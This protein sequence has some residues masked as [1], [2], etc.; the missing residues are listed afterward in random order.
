MRAAQ[1]QSK[2][3]QLHI[4][5]FIIK[6]DKPR[7][8]TPSV[9]TQETLQ[10]TEQRLRNTKEAYRPQ[11][12]EWLDSS[13]AVHHKVS[14]VKLNRLIFQPYP[15]ELVFQ[16]FT[17]SQTYS[18]PLLLRNNDKVSQPVRLELQDSEQ[19]YVLGPE[20]GSSKVAPEMAAL[21]TVFFTPQENKDYHYRLVCVTQ[22]ERF[23]I[24]VRAVGPRA[25][26]DFQDEICLPVCPVKASTEKTQLVRNIGKSK[27]KFKL[28]TQRP[29]SVTP[30]SGTLDVGEILQVTV[31]FQPTTVGDHRQELRLHYHTGEDVY[32]SL[33]GTCKELKIQLETDFLML[34]NTYINMTDTQTVSLTNESDVP[35]RYRWAVWRSQKQEDL[36]SIRESSVLQ[37]GEEEE[38]EEEEEKGTFQCEFDPSAIHHL[39]LLS[40]SL[41]KCRSQDC[42]LALSLSCITVEPMEGEIFPNTTAQFKIVF[43]P[44]EAILYQ[45]TIYCDV[46]G[47]ESRLPLTIQGEGLGPDLQL[48]YALIDMKNVFIGD[49]DRYE[50]QLSNKGPIDSPFR[51]L[52][53]DTTFGRCFSVSPEEGVVPPRACQIVEVTFQSHILGSFIEDLLLTVTGQPRPPTLTFR[54][55]VIGPTFHFNVCELNFGDVAFGFPATVTCTL[56]N[57]SFVPL[58]FALRV[59]GDGSEFPS[60]SGAKQVSDL[61]L[62]NW[63]GH[64]AQGPPV[65]FTVS[66]AAGSVRAMSD[67]TIEVTLCSNTVR[68]YRLVLVV[69]VEDVEKE[70]YLPINARCVVPDVIVE[71][72]VLDFQRCYLNHPNEQ[73]VRLTN[74]SALPAFYG[75]LDQENEEGAP[76]VF[77]SSAPRGVLL[78]GGSEELPVFLE[79]K[80][81]GKLRCSLRIAVFGSLQPL[82]VVLSC[83]GQGPVVHVSSTQLHFGRVPVLTDTAR[84][85]QLFNQSPI[86]ALFSTRMDCKKS[87]WRVEPSEGEVQPE[88]QLELKIVVHLKDK[89]HF[90]D[91]LEVSIQDSKTHIVS[92]SATGTGTTIISDKPFGPS[93]DLGTH[94]SH[95][96]CKYSFKLTNCGQRVHR[97]FWKTD[98]LCPG[99]SFLPPISSPKQR[100]ALSRGSLLSTNREKPALSLSPSRVELFPGDSVDMVLTASSDS[101]KIIKER[102]V[103]H[104]IIGLQGCRETIMSVNVTCRFVDP[105]LSISS[106]QLNFYRKKV[107]GKILQPAYEKLVLRNV[108]SLPLS[109]ELSLPEPFFLC[110]AQLENSSTTTKVSYILSAFQ[111]WFHCFIANLRKK[112]FANLVAYF[113]HFH[114]IVLRIIIKVFF[115]FFQYLVLGDEGEVELWVCFDPTF[116]KNQVSQIVDELLKIRFLEHPHQ[117]TVELHAEVHHPNLHFSAT[118]VDFGC[119]V[120]DLKTSQEISITNVSPLHVSY[121]WDF[122]DNHK[123]IH[124]RD[125]GK[126]QMKPK[127]SDSQSEEQRSSSPVSSLPPSPGPGADEQSCTPHPAHVEE[128]FDISPMRGLLPPGEREVVT[129]SFFGHEDVSREVVAQCHVA[130]GPTYEV[131]LKGETSGISYGLES[132]HLDFGLQLFYCVGEVELTVTNTGKVGFN[133]SITHPQSEEEEEKADEGGR[134][135][136]KA[137]KDE[138]LGKKL[139]VRPGWPM[140]IPA[141]GYINAGSKRHLRVLYLPG[142]PEVF[143]KQLWLQV[144]SQPP[145]KISL[146]G[147]GVFPRI[148]LN[149]PR[150]MSEERYREA[151]QQAEAAV[152]AERRREDL[153]LQKTSGG[154]ASGKAA[155]TFEE[156][157]QMETERLLVKENA[158]VLT[159]NLLELRDSPSS[160]FQWQKLS[161]SELPEYVL[162]FGLVIPDKAVSQSVNITNNG[163]VPVSFHANCKRL[164]GTGFTAEFDH[165]KNLLCGE[166]QTFTVTFDPDEPDL[167]TGK[168]DVLLPIQVA[169][170][171]QVKVRLCAAVA[172]PTITVSTGTLQFDT[173]QCCMCQI[174]TVQLMNPGSVQCQWSMTEE[175]KPFKKIDKFL[176]LYERKKLLQEQR[177]PPTVFEMLPCSGEL[178]PGERVNVHVKFSPA[179][180]RSYSRRLEVRVAHSTQLLFITAQGQGEEP[181]LEFCPSEPELGPCL[182]FSMEAEAE[183]TVKNPGSFPI[184]FYSLEFDTEHFK[185]DEVLRLMSG[186]DENNMLLLPPRVPGEGLPPELL[187]FYK[188]CSSQLKDD[189]LN[190]EML[191]DQTKK[192]DTKKEKKKPNDDMKPADFF[193]SELSRDG[194][195]WRLGPLER[196]PVFRAIARH[197]GLDLS[198]EGPV[199]Q[200]HRGISLIVYGAPQTDKSSAAAALAAHY[201]AACLNVDAVVSNVIQ[202][203]TSPVSLSA[204]Q[205]YDAAAEEYA[206]NKAAQADAAQAEPAEPA[207][208]A[209]PPLGS[210][211]A[212]LHPAESPA[213]KSESKCSKNISITHQETGDKDTSFCELQGVDVATLSSLLPEQLLVDILVERFQLIDCHRGVVIDGLTS[214]YTHSLSSTLQIILKALNNRKHIYVVNLSDTY[215]ALKARERQQ[216]EAEEALQKERAIREEKWLWELDQETF[217]ALSEEEK[218]RITHKHLVLLRQQRL[219]ELEQMAKEEEMRKQEE[220]KRLKEEE[221][222]KKSTKGGK[223]DTKDVPKKKNLMNGKQST[224]TVNV[225]RRSSSSNSK[226]SLMDT[227]EQ[228]NLN[229]AAGKLQQSKEAE[230]PLKEAEETKPVHAVSPQPADKTKK[231]KCV[232]DE[233]QRQFTE[234]EQ[235]QVAVEHI[236]RHWDRAQGLLLVPVP[237]EELHPGPDDAVTE[238]QAPAPKKSKK[239]NNKNVSP[240]LSQPAAEANNK[241]GDSESSPQIIRHIVLNVPSCSTELLS[242]GSLPPLE[243]VL[244]LGPSSPPILPPTIFSVVPF[245][246]LRDQTKVEQNCF[247]FLVVSSLDEEE[248]KKDVEEETHAKEKVSYRSHKRSLRKTSVVKEKE[249]RGKESERSKFDG[250]HSLSQTSSTSDLTDHD[251]HQRQLEMK[252][253]QSLSSF[254]WVV[255]AGGEVILKI[256]FYSE[257]PGVF[258]QTFSFELAGSRK[259]YQLPCR[260]LCTYPSICKEYKTLF[261]H[262]KKVP[263]V[264]EELQKS[265]IIKAEYFEF[266]PLLCSKTRDRFKKNKYPENSERLVIHNN[267]SL[268]AEV[269]F[270]FLQDTQA[271]TYLLDPPTMTLAPG[272]KQELTVWAYPTKQGQIKDSVVCNIKDN[273]E[274]VIINVS[275]WG[276][277]PELELES[278]HLHFGRI[279]LHRRDSRSVMMYNTTAL[280]VSWRLQGVEDL[281]DEFVV[282]QDQGVISAN[283]SFLFTVHF[284]AKRPVLIKKILRLEVSDV[285]NILGIVH[286]ENIHVTT[287]SYDVDLEITP[288]AALDFGTIRVFEET[289]QSL[290]LINKGKYELFFKFTTEQTDPP[291][292]N[293]ES[294]FT[295]SPPSGSIMPNK[296]SVTLQFTC[297]PDKELLIKEQPVLSCQVIEPSIGKEE[298]SL[299]HISIKTSVQAVFSRYKITP[300]CD[301]DFGPLVYGTKKTQTITIENNGLF[302]MVF[303]INRVISDPALQTSVPGKMIPGESFSA[304]STGTSIK[305]RQESV[306]RESSIQQNR[307]TMGVFSVSPCSG[308]VQ[309]KSQQQVTVECVAE[310]PGSWNQC[311]LI[312]VSGRDPSGQPDG[313]QYRLLAEVFKPGI[314]LNTASIFEEHFLCRSSSQLSSEPFCDA[315]G[316]YVLKENRFTFNEVL[317][318]RTAQARFRLTNNSKISCMLSLTIKYARTKVPRQMEVFGLPATTLNIPAQSHAFAVV[319][320]TP[321][322]VQHYSATFEATVEGLLRMTPTFKNKLLEFELTGEGTLPSVCVVRPALRNG[323]GSPVMQFGRVLVGRRKTLPLVLLNDGNV[324]AQVLIEMPDKDGMFTLQ[325]A[326][327]N[328]SNHSTQLQDTTDS[329]SQLMHGARLKLKSN[330]Q[331]SFEL[332]FCSDKPAG[333]EAKLTVKVED[334]QY[335]TVI[336]VTGE[337][338]RDILSLDN[339]SRCLLGGRQEDEGDYEVLHFG[340]CHV[341]CSYRRSFTM[342]NHSSSQVL[343]FQWLLPGP[344]IIFSPQVGH[345]HASSSKEVTVSFRSS[346]PVTLSNKPVGCK[347]CQVAF[348]EPV[349]QVVDWDDRQRTTMRRQ[350]TSTSSASEA[351][352]QPKIKKTDP[353]PVCSVIEGSH[354]ELN[355]H[356]SAVCDY[357]K[358]SCRTDNI[359][360]KDTIIFQTRI[361]QLQIV[362]VGRVKVEFTWQVLMDS[363]SHDQEATGETS[364]SP[365]GSGSSGP[366][367]V[368]RPSSALSSVMSILNRNPKLPPFSVEPS[369]GTIHPGSTQNF[370]VCFS[371]VEVALVQGRLI[372]SIP[373]MQ[374]GDQAPCVQVS[375][376]S[377]LPRCHF[378]LQ[379]S[380]DIRT[381][382]RRPLDPNARVLEFK[383]VGFFTPTSRCFN[384]LNPTSEAFS[385]KWTC[386]DTAGSPFHCLTSSGTVLPGKTE[387]MRFEFVAEHRDT[388]ESLWSFV[389]ETLSLSVPFLCVG[390]AREPVVYLNR[391]HLDFGELV[392]GQR[393]E[394]TVDL[395]NAEEK[396]VHVSVLQSSL[397]SEDQQSSLVVQPMNGTVAPKNRLPLS[398]RFTPCLEGHVDF[399]LHL[400]VKGKPE[401]LTLTVKAQSSVLSMSLQ[402]KKPDGDLRAVVPNLQDTLDFGEVGISEQPSFTFLVPNPVKL[403]LE[404]NFELS[405]PKE[406]LQH[407]QAK[408]QTA[409]IKVGKSLQASLVFCPRSVCNLQDVSLNLKV[410]LGPTFTFAVKGRAEAPNLEFSFTKFNFGKCFL[411]RPGMEPPSQTLMISN[412][413][414]KDVSAECQFRNAAF[415]SV[416]FQPNILR[417]GAAMEVPV[418]FHPQ[419]ARRY[420]KNITFVFNSCVT[421]HVDIQGQGIQ[422]KLDV[423]NPQQ[424]QLKLG[425]LTLGQKVKKQAVLVNQSSS[426]LSFTLT[427]ST[428][429][430]L[431]P[432]VLSVS[433]AGELKLKS[434]GGS[435]KV[436]IQFSPRRCVPPFTAELQAEFP[437]FLH[438][439]LTVDGCCQDVEVELDQNYLSFGAVVQHCR[440]RKR[441][442]MKNTGGVNAKFQWRTEQFPAELSVAPVKGSISPGMQVPLEVTFAPVELSTDTRYENLSCSFEGSSSSVT[443]TVTGSCVAALTSKE[444]VNFVCPVRSSHTQTLSILN[445]T[446]LPVNITPVL[447]G[448]QWSAVLHVTFEPY[449]NKSFDIT[450]QPLTMTADGKK[451]VGSI[452]FSFPDGRGTLYSLQGTAD[453]PKAEGVIALELPA[454]SNHC[455]ELAVSNWLSKQQRFSVLLEIIK[456]DK[457][458]A[459]VSLKGQKY[460]EVLALAKKDYT[461]SFFAYKEGNYNTKV[462]F[463]NE[464]T[465]EYL[466]YLINFKVK[467]PGVLSTISLESTV[468]QVTS[469]TVHME[470]PL[471][472]AACF[473]SEC[474]CGDISAPPQ[475]TVPGQSE[476]SLSFEY[477]PLQ[478]GEFSTQLTLFSNDLGYFHYNLLLK[479]LPP[480]PEKTVHFETS[481][482]SSHSV[483]VKFIN[484]SRFKTEYSCK[485]DCPDFIVDKSTAASPGFQSGSEVSVEVCFEPHQQGAMKSYLTV[486]SEL[487]GEYVFPLHGVCL[488]PKPQGPFSIKSGRGVTIPFKNVFLQTTAFLF[489][490]DNSCFTVK[491]ESRIPSKKT[492]NILV[493]FDAP[494]AAF[495]GPWFGKLTISGQNYSWV[496]YLK[497]HRPSSS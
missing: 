189:E 282:P 329:G 37:Q 200:S 330:E 5:Q 417:P 353:E 201:G 152:D 493:S 64:A 429:T 91:K 359:H 238:K 134:P 475:L 313:L 234:Y 451:H 342:T 472:A 326:P 363:S 190:A 84:N 267:S 291:L 447:K 354:S 265:Y 388:V 14:S 24:P 468:R 414:R 199:A 497:G 101:P 164:A 148:T 336:R 366:P 69:D 27:A 259:L 275:C 431:D 207:E 42:L 317:V 54:G 300:A 150:N 382:R 205:L 174:Q 489:Q 206:Q 478:P 420:H 244:E 171:P 453:P 215:A 63:R 231:K 384:V 324:P 89:L 459:T 82:E 270:S 467:P 216:R 285:E 368:G 432:K 395:V 389:I 287:E 247:T 167:K 153:K 491:G 306:Q 183:V 156:L 114:N 92:V 337:A 2:T 289:K 430:P 109:I 65:E 352:P 399:R 286:T 305:T 349:E 142:V 30:S 391:P 308:A 357:V 276:V 421:Q 19:F 254:R 249:K 132:T 495:P 279:L 335:N 406:Q 461:V 60:V 80:A 123:Q 283:S 116:Y 213:E 358:F 494:P 303:T 41:Q 36:A 51:F 340:D 34:K 466:F 197:M 139:E 496:F 490:V 192:D 87:F 127:H 484:Y 261:A 121:R 194:N 145:E 105:W 462:T 473:T 309:P 50:V 448:K 410:T 299:A 250:S 159:D 62:K 210:V 33:C 237:G 209:A 40:G 122:L 333:V 113:V 38:D 470:N 29:F 411:Y 449:Q 331:M 258:E 100:D 454:K 402:V 26:L 440:N 483:L 86:P 85:L 223:K 339:T 396:E 444:V 221:S 400:K 272:Q 74:S 55:C 344:H 219:R 392:V 245:P 112:S 58:T 256:W 458:D 273:P 7:R 255:P 138:G 232:V 120:N 370:S 136:I 15:S 269:K 310:Q 474:K 435:C 412:R 325:A 394:Q 271:T 118:I 202:N 295:V 266:G 140:V 16:N 424:K 195:S 168:R 415:L 315:E 257:S 39:P 319:T 218:E 428:N 77:G 104:A 433:P 253:S 157:L 181:N 260:G 332:S 374:D 355:L 76:L 17:P 369:A 115:F 464:L 328:I 243:E 203:G 439:L 427:L 327:G 298:E 102:L 8:M 301:I 380:D 401:P 456:P 233:L 487:G 418:T 48:N 229:E 290:K 9:F 338:Y 75:L 107:K 67:E 320:F 162:D 488:P 125:T 383:A 135:Q 457:T 246:K 71:T 288:E 304:K 263:Q 225:L 44:Q 307:L 35:L 378:D 452:F 96:L 413:G 144:A 390:S 482:G 404:V 248:E 465:G 173:V 356:I 165:V 385:F 379:E 492:Q 230:D 43:Q 214:L 314:L 169:G 407:L 341:G 57:T 95:D 311:L 143:E 442:V 387:E 220:K 193:V 292:P 23:E 434:G 184:E 72:P 362:N 377:L 481:L 208:P 296:K 422:I 6:E 408:P 360:F 185:E 22:R 176:P 166:T 186:Y 480:P 381:N 108:S 97:M 236:L 68:S 66:P 25:V 312:D 172:M 419:E 227:K 425:S 361:Q 129:F 146:T 13:N 443:L 485:T 322:A 149:L 224:V 11:V 426:D 79:V 111:G 211:S 187:D 188:N 455:E 124:L 277:R 78:P 151:V 196:T 393:C 302:L 436:E 318:G 398:V 154:D 321:Q 98:G 486:S 471:T 110:D 423:K 446:G 252:R 242:H 56:F 137:L 365:P 278:K 20:N 438:P 405:G 293:L 73:T 32:I 364:T 21:F 323:E 345:L 94:F 284:R 61:S 281:G 367:P 147:A 28:H 479:A 47:R 163:S 251:Q 182:P 103:C 212:S 128:V 375:G 90:Q 445:P 371:P 343:R 294:I 373:N 191:E 441:I 81:V 297:R 175:V 126:K 130:D 10:S 316:V 222:R 179:E 460:I 93:L 239:G 119:I 372:C 106:K 228:Q 131:K 155:L 160:S 133:F 45:H 409:S 117:E 52:S 347:V 376:R 180:G 53:S 403:D 204:R 170:G 348:Q 351:S 177:P 3:P 4:N 161:K 450:Y 334:S 12:L 274:S 350:S 198:P 386:E 268:E 437:G 59:L 477:L 262:S 280:P 463:C 346:Q 240:P 476:G 141:V 178:S 217:D 1:F 46:T 235:N 83:I 469:G 31:L 241:A 88:S 18:L 416:D 226:E 264:K 158:L 99:R 397:L 70:T 49:R